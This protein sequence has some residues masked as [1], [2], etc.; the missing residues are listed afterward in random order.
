M[1]PSKFCLRLNRPL[2]GAL[3]KRPKILIVMTTRLWETGI[4]LLMLVYTVEEVV[5]LVSDIE[6]DSCRDF[7]RLS[8]VGAPNGR[9][10]LAFQTYAFCVIF[11]LRFQNA[12]LG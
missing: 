3:S 9:R 10:T 2:I 1:H 12:R 7:G 6:G 5:C 8:A 11:F 4:S